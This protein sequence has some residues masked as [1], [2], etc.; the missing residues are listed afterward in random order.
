M[1]NLETVPSEA[2]SH[3]LTHDV[4]RLLQYLHEVD[5]QRGTENRNL[6]EQIENIMPMLHEILGQLG[7]RLVYEA[8]PPVP[9]KDRSVG[10]SS[11]IS[12]SPRATPVVSRDVLSPTPIAHRDVATMTPVSGQE[13]APR[14]PVDR[15]EFVSPTPIGGRHL[16]TPTPMGP[17]GIVQPS[18]QHPQRPRLI[19]ISL[20]PPPVRLSSPDSSIAESMSF[21]PSA[22]SDDLSLLES[23]SY[24]AMPPSPSWPSTSSPSPESSPPASSVSIRSRSPTPSDVSLSPTP[25]PPSLSPSSESSGTARPVPPVSLTQF[26]DVLA[27]IQQELAALRDGQAVTSQTLDELRSRPSVPDISDCCRRIE[28]TLQHLM[29]QTRRPPRTAQDDVSEALYPSG[30]DTSLLEHLRR[31]REEVSGDLPPLQ[32]PIPVRAGPSIDERLTEMMADGPPPVQQPVQLPPPIIPLTYRPGPRIAR[33]RSASPIFESDLP[34]RPGTFPISQPVVFHEGPRRPVARV[35]PRRPA[36]GPPPSEGGVSYT[37]R[38]HSQGPPI[39][40]PSAVPEGD[41]NFDD[42]VRRRRIQRVGRGSGFYVPGETEGTEHRPTTAPARFADTRPPPA[43]PGSIGLTPA[44]PGQFG[45]PGQP[46]AFVPMATAQPPTILQLPFDDILSLLRDNRAAQLANIEN[47]REVMRY[48]REL[49]EWLARDVHDRHAEVRGL[50]ARVDELRDLMRDV[51]DGRRPEGFTA[52]GVPPPPILGTPAVPVMDTHAQQPF[53]PG[54]IP[55][56]TSVIPPYRDDRTPPPDFTPVIPASPPVQ[57]PFPQIPVIPGPNVY[58]QPQQPFP[59]LQQQGWPADDER[60][61]IPPS[62]SFSDAA[63]D[64]TPS[65]EARSPDVRV[66]PPPLDPM[67]AA[68]P[69]GIQPGPPITVIPPQTQPPMIPSVIQAPMM[70]RSVEGTPSEEDEGRP[71]R[72]VSPGHSPPPQVLPEVHPPTIPHPGTPRHPDVPPGQPIPS[73]TPVIIQP[74]PPMP[75]GPQQIDVRPSSALSR[76]SRSPTRSR[77]P[78]GEPTFMIRT[79][80]SPERSARSVRSRSHSPTPIIIPPSGP[81]VPVGGPPVYLQQPPLQP[82]SPMVIRTASRPGR[83]I[84][85][86][87]SPSPT[88]LP[89]ARTPTSVTIRS[90]SPRANEALVVRIPSSS[91]RG[92]ERPRDDLGR[93]YSPH[94][95]S[96]YERT[97]SRRPSGSR[98]AP[99]RAPSEGYGDPSLARPVRPSGVRS[100]SPSPTFGYEEPESPSDRPIRQRSTG[101]SERVPRTG[102]PS[103]IPEREGSQS[104]SPTYQEESPPLV[105][106]GPSVRRDAPG[107]TPTIIDYGEIE[108]HRT[109]SVAPS[110]GPGAQRPSRPDRRPSEVT[111][112]PSGAYGEGRLPEEAEDVDMGRVPSDGSQLARD[113]E[114]ADRRTPGAS[115]VQTRRTATARSISPSFEPSHEDDAAY[116]DEPAVPIATPSVARVPTATHVPP[117]R[118]RLE[119]HFEEPDEGPPREEFAGPAVRD[120]GIVPTQPRTPMRPTAL[121]PPMPVIERI[122]G[123]GDLGFADAERER[124]DRFD[125]LERQITGTLTAAQD[126]EERREQ[127]FRGH[128]DE[129]ERVFLDREAQRDEEHRQALQRYETIWRDLEDRL[130]SIVPG[131]QAPIPVP[132]PAA[133]AEQE[134]FEHA[135]EDV[136]PTSET[137][138]QPIPPPAADAQSVIESIRS[139]TQDAATRHAQDILATVQLEREELAREREV[140]R[141]ER[142]RNQAA[143]EAERARLCEEQQARIRALEEELTLVKAELENERQLRLTEESDRR[144]HERIEILENNE[145]V[146]NQLTE[147]TNLVIQQREEIVVKR[148]AEDERWAR[149]EDYMVQSANER[150]QLSD[151]LDRILNDME[152]ERARAEEERAARADDPTLQDVLAE[153]ARVRGELGESVAGMLESIRAQCAEQHERTMEAVRATAHDR[154]SFNV[155]EYLEEFSRS[156]ADEVRM[157]LNEVGRLREERRKEQYELGEM[158]QF[159]AKFGPGGTFDPEWRPAFGPYARGG[160]GAPPAE[161]PAEA[162]PPPPEEPLPARP[163]WRQVIAPRASRRS[164]RNQPAPPPAPEAPPEPRGPV[165]WAQWR[166][167]SAFQP[168]P[169]AVEPTLL[170]PPQSSP[171]LFGPRSPRD[172]LHR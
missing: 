83:H 126:A 119:E 69:F 143:M 6:A 29:D 115:R 39:P 133:E 11:I 10:G 95:G 15:R 70:E 108:P 124:Q 86:S 146:R 4:N 90:R 47:N 42:E 9:R 107:A 37:P 112:V 150:A 54:F 102:R 79:E 50:N 155:Q 139:V 45:T 43:V 87:R 33:P 113:Y 53:P 92:P 89:R 56:P 35:P 19:A 25:P 98:R 156:L 165:S 167:D 81:H 105:M 125:E 36:P 52:P 161:A 1:S 26:R 130:A 21:L 74:A 168:T 157:L 61:V 151:K 148:D 93:P 41:I 99:S 162:P 106:R 31:F 136:A 18:P 154:I 67:Q 166:P 62:P 117:P 94:E 128:E 16:V 121:S 71:A 51:L 48:L 159:K 104:P 138:V 76:R 96:Q 158:L 68:P 30:S 73:T 60:D 77:S 116:E 118:S 97:T 103:P 7:H 38:V 44:P 82:M 134:E 20:S 5:Q 101:R 100:R 84:D 123:P 135:M 141:A 164:R 149:K 111:M 78:S 72:F 142:E 129:R 80:R 34:R 22:H 66:I 3:I 169:P 23:E 152:A 85:V 49:N 63:S 170:A 64:L 13:A 46:S 75:P 153:L 24:P 109:P 120:Q 12:A 122:S 59:P 163:A 114:E 2:P 8:A 160:P 172:S 27:Q 110:V 88:L 17:R 55:Q 14:T 32:M 131:A 145:A 171:G 57:M 40:G 28:E 140:E 58:V 147:L 91:R 137:P 65:D 132:P 144:E 127:S